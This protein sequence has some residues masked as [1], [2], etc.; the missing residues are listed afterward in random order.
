MPFQ[1][2]FGLDAAQAEKLAD[3]QLAQRF[4]LVPGDGQTLQGASGNVLAVRGECLGDVVGEFRV[5]IMRLG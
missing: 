4:L 3:L 2:I 1:E 5:T